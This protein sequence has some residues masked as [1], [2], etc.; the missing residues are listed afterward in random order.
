MW[1]AGSI[2]WALLLL[3]LQR[4]YCLGMYAWIFPLPVSGEEDEAN[5]RIVICCK[6]A[7]L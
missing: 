6:F 5:S 2:G 7:A 1:G 4:S 3:S